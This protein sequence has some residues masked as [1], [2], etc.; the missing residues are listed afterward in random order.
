VPPRLQA[1]EPVPD[2]GKWSEQDAI[3][4]LDVADPE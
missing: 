4:D 2:P 1:H 3:G